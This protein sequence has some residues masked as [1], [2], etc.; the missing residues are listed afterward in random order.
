M[1]RRPTALTVASLAFAGI[2]IA[3]TPAARAHARTKP[4]ELTVKPGDVM[5]NTTVTVRGRGFADRATI[6]LHEC[7]RTSWLVPDEPCGSANVVSIETNAHGGFSTSMKAEVCPEGM[8]GKVITE[9]TCYVGVEKV[10]EDTG[11]LAPSAKLIV[12][13]P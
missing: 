4:G 6:T 10:I 7:G 11:A 5:V 12:T 9:R 3:G 13:Y 1:T 2:A 8:P